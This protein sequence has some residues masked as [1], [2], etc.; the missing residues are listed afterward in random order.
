MAYRWYIAQVQA[1]SENSAIKAL[2]EQI[3]RKGMQEKFEEILLPTREV[4]EVKNGKRVQ[5]DK[6]FFPGYV[7]LKMEMNE[8]TW[9][10]VRG[11][12]RITGFLSAQN[13]PVP[14]TQKEADT[15]LSSL[16]E[17]KAGTVS[18]E[19][20]Q[21]GDR[22][23]VVSGP[24]ASFNGSVELVDEDK[25]R[26]KVSVLVFGRPTQVDLEFLQVEKE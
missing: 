18:L 15:L 24:F 1:G 9:Q 10:L 20:F 7:L 26:L 23:K 16:D 12:R 3:E 8:E 19:T 5:S 2:N 6:K 14:L 4:T 21:I 25:Q 11:I 22:V 17:Q 13:K